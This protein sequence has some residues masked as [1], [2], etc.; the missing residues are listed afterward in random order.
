MNQKNI[1]VL[2]GGTSPEHDISMAS[3]TAVISALGRH[4]VIPVYITRKGQWLLYDGKL[5]NIKS[6]DWEKFGTPTVLSPDR[7]HRGLLRIVGDKV[8]I[9]PVDVVF[10][11]LHGQDGEDG[12]IQGLCQLA[13]IPCI[14]CGVLSSAISMDKAFAKIIAKSLKIPQVDYLVF[15]K[16]EME[17]TAAV[18]KKIRYKLGYPCFVKPAV[19][20]SSIGITKAKNKEELEVAIAEALKYATKVV[21]EKGINGR[22]LEIGVLGNGAYAK[23][24]EVGEVIPDG[25]FYDFDAKYVKPDSKTLIPADIP[26]EAGQLIKKY[27]LE[28]FKGVDGRGMARVDFFLDEN[29]KVLLNE[30]NTVPG[31]TNISMYSKLWEKSGIPRQDLIENLIELA[32]E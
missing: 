15:R 11:A 29:G 32:V 2:F 14:G 19:G 5:D 4:N 16:E 24:S 20:G 28:M 13:G 8:K 18:T 25:E 6:I 21:V 26:E 30:I 17:D 12:T 7:T 3:A 9:I 10:P 31:Y 23:A 22:E 1:L 27:A